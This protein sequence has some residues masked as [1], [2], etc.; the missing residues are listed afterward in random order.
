VL[1]VNDGDLNSSCCYHIEIN[2]ILVV[3]GLNCEVIL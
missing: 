1:V 2:L 3:S